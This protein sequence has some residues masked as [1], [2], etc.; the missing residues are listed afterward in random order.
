MACKVSGAAYD[1]VM[2]TASRPCTIAP[3]PLQ[4]WL[5]LGHPYASEGMLPPPLCYALHARNQ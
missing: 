3:E 4:G 5:L 2:Q 1:V